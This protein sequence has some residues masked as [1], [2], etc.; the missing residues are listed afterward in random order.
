MKA[1]NIHW[2]IDM[3]C[4]CDILDEMSAKEAAKALELPYDT[5]ANMTDEEKNDWVYDFFSNRPDALMEFVDLPSE[6]ELPKNLTDEDDISDWLSD[7][8]G[9]CHDGFELEG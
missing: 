8:Y 5:Y 1:K 2:D 3:E 7:E 9:F 4:V 6:V